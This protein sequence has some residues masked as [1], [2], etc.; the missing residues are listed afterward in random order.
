MGGVGGQFPRNVK[1]SKLA[2]RKVIQIPECVKF[3]PVES[4]ILGSRILNL[5]EE[6]RNPVNDWNP[7]S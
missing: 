5:A 7:E 1:W 6:I 4:E 2:P 3:L